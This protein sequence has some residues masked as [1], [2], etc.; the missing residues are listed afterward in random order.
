MTRQKLPL[1]GV[2]PDTHGGTRL[3]TRSVDEKVLYV[4]D[5]YVRAVQDQ[6]AA[7]VILPVTS[8]RRSLRD[9]LRRLDGLLLIGGNFDIPPELY[10]EAPIPQLGYVKKERSEFEVLLIEA[11]LER[12]LPTLG[13]CG[14]MQT[15]NVVLGGTLYQDIETQRPGSRQHQ[16][17]T[18]KDRVSHR[19]TIEAGTL[20]HRIVSG[21]RNKRAISIGV[22]STHHQAIKDLGRGLVTSAAAA[23]GIVEGL[24]S[25]K[26]AFVVGVQWHPELLCRRGKAHA[27]LFT[28]LSRAAREFGGSRCSPRAN[29]GPRST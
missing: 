8:D 9:T 10:G 20:L 5:T 4:Y 22:N 6:G 23:D 29:R 7:T 25:T 18:R 14:G 1:V 28:A 26:H 11:A 24:E 17:Q 12:N 16:Q 21:R 3:R 15:I 19:V 27:R 2:T 13:I